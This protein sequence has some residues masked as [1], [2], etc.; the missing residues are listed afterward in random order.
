MKYSCSITIN[1]PIEEVIAKFDNVENLKEWMPGLQ[2]FTHLSGEPGQPGAQSKLV[3]QMGKRRI[4]MVETVTVRDL[5][6]EFSGTYDASGVHNI[7]QN[8][9]EA[10]GET[11][12]IY[13]T[14]QEFQFKGGMKIIGWLFPGAFKKQ[15]MKYLTDFKAFVEK[16]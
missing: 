12:T 14:D 15:S 3:F 6:R 2:E 4:E 16:N 1:K 7:V 11:Q 10:S 8:Y 9:F 13:K 5:P